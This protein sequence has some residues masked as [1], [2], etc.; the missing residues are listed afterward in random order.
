MIA[1]LSALFLVGAGLVV[2]LPGPSALAVS[3]RAPV[4]RPFLVAPPESDGTGRAFH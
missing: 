4:A 1:R 3:P 2:G